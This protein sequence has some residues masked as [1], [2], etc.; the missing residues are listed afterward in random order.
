MANPGADRC[1]N[2]RD[3]LTCRRCITKGKYRSRACWQPKDDDPD[4]KIKQTKFI[5]AEPTPDQPG[6]CNPQ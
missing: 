2:Y 4:R 6:R 1:A 5:F 3:T